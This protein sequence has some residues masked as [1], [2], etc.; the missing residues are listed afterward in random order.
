MELGRL[1]NSAVRDILAD[2]SAATNEDLCSLIISALSK[3][4]ASKEMLGE[5]K[6]SC[7]FVNAFRKKYLKGFDP[8]M[9]FDEAIRFLVDEGYLKEDEALFGFW[10]NLFKGDLPKADRSTISV[11]DLLSGLPLKGRAKDEVIE[12]ALASAQL[13]LPQDKKKP[14]RWIQTATADAAGAAIGASIAGGGAIAGAVAFSV[15]VNM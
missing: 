13:D 11:V 10:S 2:G 4:G 12:I 8:S 1:H 5:I 14:G 7:G 15:M 9:H 6:S 3:H